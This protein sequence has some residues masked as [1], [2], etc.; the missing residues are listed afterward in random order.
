LDENCIELSDFNQHISINTDTVTTKSIVNNQTGLGLLQ[1]DLDK[2]YKEYFTN[3]EFNEFSIY[4]IEKLYND[5][6]IMLKLIEYFKKVYKNQS[7]QNINLKA[8]TKNINSDI[9]SPPKSLKKIYDN[10]EKIEGEGPN[11]LDI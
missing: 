11:L 5:F 2:L 9:L 4:K 7:T 1:V 6:R 8:A 10:E 3:I